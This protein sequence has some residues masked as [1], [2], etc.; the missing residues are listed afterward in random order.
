[1]K[2]FFIIG[3]V[4]FGF[5]DACSSKDPCEV[6]YTTISGNVICGSGGGSAS[7]SNAK[8]N[9]YGELL[10]YN[11]TITCDSKIYSGSVT[12]TYSNHRISSTHLVVNGKTCY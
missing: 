2:K 1:V 11:F 3:L 10:S 4:V 12:I 8:Y 9:E 5:L 7:V 6:V